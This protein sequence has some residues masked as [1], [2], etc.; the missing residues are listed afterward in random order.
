MWEPLAQCTGGSTPVACNSA[1]AAPGSPPAACDPTNPNN[2]LYGR[3]SPSN[4]PG[5]ACWGNQAWVRMDCRDSTN[6][7]PLNNPQ[8]PLDGPNGSMAQSD[9][10]VDINSSLVFG[11]SP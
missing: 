4:I 11:T 7:I 3:C 10:L 5:T 2:P 6:Y 8:I 9:G 1:S